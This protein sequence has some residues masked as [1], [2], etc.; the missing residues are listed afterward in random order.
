[1]PR[2]ELSEDAERELV[3]ATIDAWATRELASGGPLVAV[4][5]VEVTDGTASHRWL[6]RFEGEEKSTIAT[7]LTFQQRTLHYETE[8]MPMPEE[9]VLEVMTYLLRRNAALF[10]MAFAI[11]PEDSLYLVGRTPAHL[12]DD[13]ELDRIAGCSL[14]WVD[15]HYPTA[16]TLGY[17]GLYRRRRRSGR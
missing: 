11:G 12:V 9:N 6:L 8:L 16:M 4:E 13:D 14:L 15:D 3:V 7:W 2:V 10:Q 5:R 17:P 1:V